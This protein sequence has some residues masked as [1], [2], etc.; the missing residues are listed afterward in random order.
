MS[1]ESNTCPSHV[2]TCPLQRQT[3]FWSI[4]IVISVTKLGLDM[5]NIPVVEAAPNGEW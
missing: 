1:I 3:D 2:L 4:V 5:S